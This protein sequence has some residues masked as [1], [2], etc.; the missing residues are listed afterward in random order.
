MKS[1]A[2]KKPYLSYLLRLW[3]VQNHAGCL[4]RCL[5]DNVRTG[6]RHGFADL[7]A[8]CEFLGREVE[9]AAKTGRADEV[10]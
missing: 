5:L 8:L 3:P 9:S 2:G 10:D 7:E 1:K 6:E 4:W